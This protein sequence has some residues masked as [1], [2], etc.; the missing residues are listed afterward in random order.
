MRI[1]LTII[2]KKNQT[3]SRKENNTFNKNSI[4]IKTKAK[5][6]NNKIEPETEID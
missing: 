5:L 2:I 4:S 3:F 6:D 1:I